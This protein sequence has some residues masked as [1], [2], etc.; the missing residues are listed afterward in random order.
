MKKHQME[1]SLAVAAL[2]AVAGVVRADTTNT[3]DQTS[4]VSNLGN[5]SLA[6][7]PST[8]N[9]ANDPS[10]LSTAYMQATTQD[11]HP[12]LMY[13]LDQ[14]N[15]GNTTVGDWLQS[16]NINIT[17]YADVGYTA[18]LSGRNT[19]T[20]GGTIPG[21]VFDSNY[22]NH[23]DLNQLEL[24]ISRSINFTD[25]GFRNR[26]WDIG[27]TAEF[28]YGYDPDFIQT[29]GWN[30]YHAWVNN[31]NTYP[32]YQFQVEQLFGQIA[33]PVGD[34]GALQVEAGKFDTLLGYE[35]IDATGNLFYSHS[36][37][38]NYSAP[39]TNTGALV[40]YDPDA[41]TNM[42]TFTLGPVWG[43]NQTAQF[44]NSAV[45]FMG[46]VAYTPNSEWK[47]VVNDIVGPP[48][49]GTDTEGVSHSDTAHYSNV[50]DFLT[51]YTP[52]WNTNLSFG[53]ETVWGYG[54]DG[55]ANNLGGGYA[56]TWPSPATPF[57]TPGGSVN[58]FG[59]AFYESYVI[60]S[61]LTWNNRQ[62]YYYD[63]F[64]FS[65]GLAPV[66][67][68]SELSLGEFTTGLKI[69]PMPN[70]NLGQHLYLRPELRADLADHGVLTNGKH[71]QTTAAMD[72]I[73]Q[74]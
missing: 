4:D 32:L 33:I 15:A 2:L 6:L 68:S 55:D 17:G 20:A 35:V 13:G 64:N 63:G 38:F 22:G 10:N 25:P 21:R 40:E 8:T 39:F 14:V 59:T 12:A 18:D 66:G 72:V 30:F 44:L 28:L 50:L 70:S 24:E 47:F 53:N 9:Q 46:Q 57:G 29:N 41:T 16:L 31:I 42:W 65:T 52:A 73:Y 45:N 58:W 37:I 19:T 43:W 5:V 69:T 56:N 67:S 34:K 62:E 27:G 26:G 71:Y 11:T 1:V 51:Y 36:F 3:A 74:F 49:G 61:Y 54:Y 7:T 60:N 48:Y 23:V